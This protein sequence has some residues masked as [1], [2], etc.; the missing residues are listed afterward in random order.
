MG[1]PSYITN[2]FV[3]IRQ[4]EKADMLFR[5]EENG[6]ATVKLDRYAIIPI[7]DYYTLLDKGSDQ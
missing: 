5:F 6:S 3:K 4:D 1:S 7:E 2:C